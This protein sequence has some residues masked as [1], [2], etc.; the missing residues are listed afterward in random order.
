[1]A[2]AKYFRWQRH[3]LGEGMENV[4]KSLFAYSQAG[5]NYLLIALLRL[6]ILKYILR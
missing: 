6:F 1:M 3:T 5:S 4:W 2:H